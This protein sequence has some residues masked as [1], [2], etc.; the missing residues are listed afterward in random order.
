MLVCCWMRQLKLFGKVP[1]RDVHILSPWS[2]EARVAISMRF[3]S[4]L[5]KIRPERSDATHPSTNGDPELSWLVAGTVVCIVPALCH[6]WMIGLLWKA[7]TAVR[8]IAE[9]G[10]WILDGTVSVSIYCCCRRCHQN[11]G[12]LSRPSGDLGRNMQRRNIFIL[13]IDGAVSI[14]Y[15]S[16]L[17]FSMLL[18]LTR[19]KL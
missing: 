5:R 8:C 10:E 4:W 17:C 6:E 11:F 7:S 16:V 18:C 1:G 13:I 15:D 2:W 3:L 12:K 9:N 19:N 14:L